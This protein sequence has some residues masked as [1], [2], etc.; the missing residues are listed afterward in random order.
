MPQSTYWAH[1]KCIQFHEVVE[2]DHQVDE[3]T[4]IPLNNKVCFTKGFKIFKECYERKCNI[5]EDE[6]GFAVRCQAKANAGQCKSSFHI[7]CAV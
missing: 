5:C 3:K 4:K 7:G 6:K 2:Y 1:I